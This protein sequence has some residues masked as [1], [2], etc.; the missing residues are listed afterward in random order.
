M[1]HLGLHQDDALYL[2]GAKSL[3]EGRGYRIDSLPGA[4]YQTKY[5]PVLPLL[6]TPVWKYGGAFPE[7][8]K[9]AMVAVWL[10]LPACLLAMRTVFRAYG[11]RPAE[12]WLLTL[13]AAWQPLVCPLSTSVMSDLLFLSAFLVSVRWAERALDRAAHGRLAFAAGLVGGLAYLTR[14][15]ALPLLAAAPLCFFLRREARRGGIF[16]AGMLPAVAGW[17]IWTWAHQL[18]TRDPALLYYTSYLGMARATVHLDNVA[19][20]LWHNADALLRAIGKLVVF[21]VALTQ[22]V[23]VE[24]ILGVAA[25][26]GAWRLLKRNRQWQYG[27][28]AAGIAALLVCHHFPPDE[29]MA[30]PLY[31]LVLMGFW[32]EAK[33]F[34]RAV[35]VSWRRHGADRLAGSVGVAALAGL[36]IF[37]VGGDAAGHLVFLP[38]LY[39]TCEQDLKRHMPAY[40]WIRDHTAREATFYAYDDPVLYLYTGRRALGL[41]MPPTRNYSGDAE[42][43][44]DRFVRSIPGEA[45]AHH[46]DYLLVTAVDF[47]REQ[48][49]GLL[50]REAARDPLLI[51]EFVEPGAAVYRTSRVTL[52]R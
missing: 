9:A 27:A 20:V 36:G 38:R 46:L 33:N 41:P 48:R 32:T 23:H 19:S 39:A 4:P 49:A 30:L 11:F 15:A 10:M 22:N 37:V 24:R 31:P 5:P 43:A 35:C 16:L 29:R 26:A 3:A 52:R 2:V 25:I 14:T 7:N 50:L 47:Y 8:L 18:H 21:D 34:W 6:L 42:R 44:A 13:A 12:V 45:R 28:A 40:E 1:P 17:Q 51:K